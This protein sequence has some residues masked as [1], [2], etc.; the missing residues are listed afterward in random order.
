MDEVHLDGGDIGGAVR[1]HEILT[2]LDGETVG[3]ARPWPSWV[4]ADGTFDRLARWMR[5]F[6]EAVAGFVPPPDGSVT[7]VFRLISSGRSRSWTLC[8][9]DAGPPG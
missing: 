9:S 6:H 2:F 5:E 3:N 8:A 4:H 1:V 7:G